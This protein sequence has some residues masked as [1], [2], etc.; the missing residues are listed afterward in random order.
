ML[1]VVARTLETLLLLLLLPP[2]LL[3]AAAEQEDE[4]DGRG[5]AEEG[6][7]GV[8]EEAW[9]VAAEAACPWEDR[10]RLA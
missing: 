7:C 4:E 10:L 2:P 9:S 6:D 5:L 3:F 8:L 1:A